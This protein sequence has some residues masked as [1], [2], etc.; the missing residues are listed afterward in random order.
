MYNEHLHFK[1]GEGET[2][3]GPPPPRRFPEAS[4]LFEAEAGLDQGLGLATTGSWA[5]VCKPGL[6]PALSVRFCW[7]T[8][9]CWRRAIRD[10]FCAI[11]Q[12][13]SCGPNRHIFA[14]WPTKHCLWNPGLG[15]G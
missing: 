1:D 9:T 5:G 15:G 10:C 13:G 4:Q 8:D 14:L 3:R 7:D 11:M 6:P 2:L 12:R